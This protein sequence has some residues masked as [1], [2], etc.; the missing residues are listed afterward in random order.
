M[1]TETASAPATQTTSAISAKEAASRML[2]WAREHRLLDVAAAVAHGSAPTEP[3]DGSLFP[4]NHPAL[5]TLRAKQ[6]LGVAFS[7]SE[8]TIHVLT[9]KKITDR[10]IKEMPSWQSGIAV[11]YLH[12]GTAQTGN[13]TM[14]AN[15]PSYRELNGRYCCGSSVHPARYPGAGTI[16]CLLKDK[17]GRLYG[18]S[19]NHVSG[20]S[21]YSESGEKIL[22]PGHS[23]ITPDGRDPFTI[24]VHVKALPMTQ[25]SMA[26]VDIR[27]NTDAAIFAIRDPNAVSSAQGGH[28]DTPSVV[29]DPA[30]GMM[31][32][33]V[34]RTSG[35]TTGRIVGVSVAALP[36]EYQMPAVKGSSVVY[37]DGLS[38]IR[39]ENGEPFSAPG[40]SG[41]LV[42]GRAKDG[43]SCAVGLLIAGTREGLSLMLP[44]RPIL[45]ALDMSLVSGHHA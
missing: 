24:G 36:I 30:G 6:I 27:H 18:L 21:N 38:V 9:R 7:D 31:V 12:I 39:G 44:I 16:G 29:A 14:A 4:D 17:E 15:G 41:S 19:A 42:I 8:R 11:N 45:E 32:E 3:D 28:F 1:T 34:A 40:D 25:G 20:L 43:T 2:A 10:S 13:H 37:F 33:K 23:D 22:A 35:Y 5:P 26:N